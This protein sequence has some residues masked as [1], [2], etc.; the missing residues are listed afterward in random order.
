MLP[1]LIGVPFISRQLLT[2][3]GCRYVAGLTFC[4]TG[5]RLLAV[6]EGRTVR[7]WDLNLDVTVA[8]L[9]SAHGPEVTCLAFNFGGTLLVTGSTDSVLRVFSVTEGECVR[10]IKGHADRVTTVA[11][12]DYRATDDDGTDGVATTETVGTLADEPTAAHSGNGSSNF[13][14]LVVGNPGVGKTSF[15]RQC[16]EGYF[17]DKYKATIG[18]DFS[19]VDVGGS[20]GTIEATLAL[21]DIAGQERFGAMNRIYFKGAYGAFVMVDASDSVALETARLWKKELD[22]KVTAPNG[23]NVPTVLL[24]NKCDLPHVLTDASLDRF[25]EEHGFSAW[26]FT[27]AKEGTNVEECNALILDRIK[28]ADAG[29]APATQGIQLGGAVEEPTPCCA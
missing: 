18:V 1:H 8:T 19:T 22:E 13:K 3:V 11:F 7:V 4:R 26:L 29:R 16:A 14:V 10:E 27:S 5:G 2:A 25:C 20:D 9:G 12:F 23:D 28:A 15:I 17:M 21:W 6:G 24:A